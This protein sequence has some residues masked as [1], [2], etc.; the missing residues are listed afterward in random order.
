MAEQSGVQSMDRSGV[1]LAFESGVSRRVEERLGWGELLAWQILVLAGLLLT[2][3]SSLFRLGVPLTA[4]HL[5][6]AFLGV[7]LT[8]VFALRRASRASWRRRSAQAL[9][10]QLLLLVACGLLAEHLPD[11]SHDG[12][13]YHQW[14]LWHLLRGWTLD[15][16]LGN[17]YAQHYPH[18]AEILATSLARVFGHFEAGKAWNLLLAF[19]LFFSSR[20]VLTRLWGA[21]SREASVVA[22]LIAFCPLVVVQAFTFYVDAQLY[23][24]LGC[25]VS[26]GVRLALSRGSSGVW[27]NTALLACGVGAINTKFTGLVFLIPLSAAV[28]L[29]CWRIA[30]EVPYRQG[31]L[32]FV[33]CCFAIGVVGYHPYITNT[34]DHGSPFYPVRER[35][36]LSEQT[37]SAF[38][39]ESRVV[40]VTESLFSASQGGGKNKRP[41][42]KIPFT[43]SAGEIAQFGT[44]DVRHGGWGPL[45]SGA[46]VLAGVGLSLL[47]FEG[48][49]GLGVALICALLFGSAVALPEGGWSARLAPQLT[50]L[51][52]VVLIGCWSSKRGWTRRLGGGLAFVLG[53]NLALVASVSGGAQVLRTLAAQEQEESLRAASLAGRS[54]AVRFAAFPANAMR[55][56]EAGIHYTEVREL[57]CRRPI[58]LIVGSSSRAATQVCVAG[59]KSGSRGPAWARLE[60][61]TKRAKSR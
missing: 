40:Q 8:L 2:G 53:L 17:I 7:S 15:S 59:E 45:F 47:L 37:S 46:L 56:L 32:L 24:W 30:H 28:L 55:L 51:P 9:G 35:K 48:K 16:D 6:A 58:R 41:H 57:P 33:G 25:F 11:F 10:A 18:G 43:F 61:W 60:H 20:G 42:W 1:T 21:R 12:Q 34:R 36:V 39:R 3:S 22:G 19:A 23:C 29:L 44:V 26:W 54:I 38:Q 4:L 52:V 27:G 5:P 49:L 50:L 13:G 31:A 14:A